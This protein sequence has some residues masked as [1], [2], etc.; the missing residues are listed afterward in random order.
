MHTSQTNQ[1]SRAS[2]SRIVI[3][4]ALVLA[5][6]GP[7]ALAPSG[8]SRG[9]GDNKVSI[10]V[11]G[12]EKQIYLPAKLADSL[13]A[14]GRAGLEVELLSTPAG[15]E[16]VN[17][18]L[19]GAVHA[20]VGFYDH[21]IDLQARGKGIQCIVQFS[22]APGEV[23]L[24]SSKRA[25]EMHTPADFRGRTI[26]VTGLG[27]STNFLIQ[28][29]A[30]KHGVANSEFSVLPVGAGNTFITAMQQGRI[31]AGM[32]TEPTIS[33]LVKTGEASVMI[34]LRTPDSTQ[35]ALGGP[36]PAA[37]LY[38]QTAW[39]ESNR[40]TAQKLAAALVEAL[41]F[42][43]T[44]SAAE[45]ADK[46]PAQ[47]YAGDRELYVRALAEGKSMFTPDGKMPPGGPE[48]VLSVL[49]GFNNNVKGKVIDLSKTFT[50]ELVDAV[51]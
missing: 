19:A 27:S 21:T 33:R 32:T 8:C 11:G 4:A 24:V 23:V 38:V 46:M 16:A 36:Y 7:S 17:E 41:R 20:V 28:Y 37:C 48:M 49:A 2:Q 12:L 34:D 26:G 39:L 29:L 6:L 31:D 9:G 25:G 50:S 44:H 42:I 43:D 13:G 5:V 51:H 14:F 40:A 47:F 30:S 18:L 10:M 15:V 3:A 45:I 22:R 35:A 1:N